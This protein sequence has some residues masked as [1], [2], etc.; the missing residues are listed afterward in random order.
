MTV[1]KGVGGGG[2]GE[3]GRKGAGRGGL[4]KSTH[5]GPIRPAHLGTVRLSRQAR[6][7][8]GPWDAPQALKNSKAQP[9]PAL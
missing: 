5:V 7:V 6:F 4:T 9:N 1:G 8:Q 2:W 3:G